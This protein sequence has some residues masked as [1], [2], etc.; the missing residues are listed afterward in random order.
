MTPKHITLIKVGHSLL[1]VAVFAILYIC[2]GR[3]IYAFL[4][5]YKFMWDNA[6]L[7]L[8]DLFVPITNMV[9]C[10]YTLS[11]LSNKLFRRFYEWKIPFAVNVLTALTFFNM[12][13]AVVM[14]ILLDD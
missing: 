2:E 13:F 5:M 12:L 6:Q 8:V 14:S 10:I 4:P 9:L 3:V 1:F 7:T 11:K